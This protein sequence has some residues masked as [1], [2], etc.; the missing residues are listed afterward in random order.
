MLAGFVLIGQAAGT[1]RVSDLVANPPT[2][3]TVTVGAM[4]VLVGA[5]TKSAQYPFHSWLPGA[6]VAPTPVSAYLHS[7]TMV[8][9]GVYLVARLAPGFVVGARLAAGR[10]RRRAVHD[11]RGRA[12]GTAAVRPEAAAGPWDRQSARPDDGA[13]RR[14]AAPA[15]AAGCALLL[16]HG[17]FKAALFMVTGTID[18][19][20]GTRDIRRIP[21]LGPRWRS[22]VIAG[23]IAAAS[24]AG[25]PL[26][27]GFVAKEAAY[28]SM[29]HGGFQGVV[30]R[31]GVHR[32][33]ARC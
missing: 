29:L 10:R 18:H 12:A 23:V 11:D 25:V 17:L 20:T 24:M 5:F 21:P 16:A 30:T 15:A 27:F 7:A 4:L 26:A 31:R 33:R 22:T 19:Q 14:R 3:T 1:Y 2:G 28:E 9:A 13:V 6:M 32:G 8:K